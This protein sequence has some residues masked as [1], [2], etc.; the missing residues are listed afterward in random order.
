MSDSLCRWGFNDSTFLNSVPI[1]SREPGVSKVISF[2]VNSVWQPGG[3]TREG[4]GRE[5]DILKS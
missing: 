1:V 3:G 5:G 4:G 2:G